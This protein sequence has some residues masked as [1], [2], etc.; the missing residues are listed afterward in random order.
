MKFKNIYYYVW[1]SVK[2]RRWGVIFLIS[3]LSVIFC[4][5]FSAFYQVNLI[6]QEEK[7]RDKSLLIPSEQVVI[8]N[9][10]DSI[11]KCEL[12]DCIQ[13]L[14]QEGINTV[15]AYEGSMYYDFFGKSL[16][17]LSE[18]QSALKEIKQINKRYEKMG[19]GEIPEK[20]KELPRVTGINIFG[21][22]HKMF[23]IKLAE[24]SW[25]MPD[26]KKEI[27]LYL[28][29]N[30]KDIAIGTVYQEDVYQYIVK[31]TLQEN[32]CLIN[33]KKIGMNFESINPENLHYLDNFVLC[34]N[35]EPD[36]YHFVLDKGER[37]EE[38]IRVITNK[39]KEK[40]GCNIYLGSIDTVKEQK[41]LENQPFRKLLY[42][43]IIL[44]TIAI[45]VILV[46]NQV[47]WIINNKSMYGIYLA[48]GFTKKEI[49]KLLLIENSI[50][51][52]IAFFVSSI[53]SY[54]INIYIDYTY[55]EGY[56]SSWRHYNY[57]PVYFSTLLAV[58]LF[59][60]LFYLLVC[61]VP[62]RMIKKMNPADFLGGND[63]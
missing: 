54:I 25:E 44:A 19:G 2:H 29:A 4:L 21:P 10:A 56:L 14:E 39:L 1:L 35:S 11:D 58:L 24:G 36:I 51:Y 26:T 9:F 41:L 62:I 20:L 6:L 12:S 3:L 33:M 34:M 27:Y 38:E 49:L 63:T 31:G 7:V 32:S 8:G 45:A 18:K 48:N 57:N 59:G 5:F 47:A 30:I 43:L 42:Q 53:M 13:F 22:I 60:I 23:D 52:C 37:S 46:S 55:W 28:G 61:F 16:A 50:Y 40:Y 17:E 15:I